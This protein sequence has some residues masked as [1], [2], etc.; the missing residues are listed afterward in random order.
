MPRK[1][2]A[3]IA[4][5]GDA[6]RQRRRDGARRRGKKEREPN[7]PRLET[8]AG[9]AA[10]VKLSRYN[11]LFFAWLRTVLERGRKRESVRA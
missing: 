7:V 9:Y 3:S 6:L 11:L 4:G 5:V 10:S 1:P 2:G 8:K